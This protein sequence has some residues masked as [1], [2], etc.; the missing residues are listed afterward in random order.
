MYRSNALLT[1]LV[2]F[3]FT[4]VA[5][6]RTEIKG[7]VADSASNELLEMA[8]ITAQD[9]KDSSLITYTL[10][11]KKGAFRLTGLPSGKPVRVL[12]SYTG[13]RTDHDRRARPL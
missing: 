6:Q 7:A 4:A 2:L 12:V 10:S 9:P 1:F 3:C 11:D 13:Y 8:T 5:Q